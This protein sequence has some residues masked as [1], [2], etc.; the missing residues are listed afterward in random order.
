MANHKDLDEVTVIPRKA[1]YFF[2]LILQSHLTSLHYRRT[3][4]EKAM[5]ATLV[6]PIKNGHILLARK[7]KKVGA[8]KWNGFGG[9]PEPQDISIRDT[10][11]RELFEETGHGINTTP[12]DLIPKALIDFFFFQNNS[13]TADF[14]VVV[15]T[16]ETFSGEAT[17]TEEMQTPTWFPIESIP[18]EE[19]L[20]ADKEFIPKVLSAKNTF[21]GKV[22]FNEDMTLVTESTYTESP[23]DI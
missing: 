15:Y 7:M 1:G 13:T 17:G 23:L 22:R 9:K 19:M 20:P 14:S 5:K 18:Y 3:V 4:K 11:C 16:T 12:E 21:Y 10:A 2:I 6:F 8:G